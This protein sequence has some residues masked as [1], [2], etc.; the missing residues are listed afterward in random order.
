MICQETGVIGLTRL[1]TDSIG[2]QHQMFSLQL[3][4]SLDDTKIGK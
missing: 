2:P 1:L 3:G 4:F